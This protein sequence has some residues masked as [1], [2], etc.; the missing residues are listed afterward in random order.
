MAVVNMNVYISDKLQ[1]EKS[2]QQGDSSALYLLELSIDL[3][4]N[5]AEQQ[6]HGTRIKLNIFLKS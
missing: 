6:N 1:L 5:Y 4:F 2:V 3:L